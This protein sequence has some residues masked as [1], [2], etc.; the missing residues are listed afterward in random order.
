MQNYELLLSP[1]VNQ[2][3]W[4]L[5][6]VFSSSL[7]SQITKHLSTGIERKSCASFRYQTDS[8]D[9]KDDVYADIRESYFTNTQRGTYKYIDPEFKGRNTYRELKLKS[10]RRERNKD[11]RNRNGR[12]RD[13]LQALNSFCARNLQD[14]DK[15]K[16]EEILTEWFI[17]AARNLTVYTLMQAWTA[18]PQTFLKIL[19]WTHKIEKI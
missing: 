9:E 17:F 19:L 1:E 15:S 3:A 12:D 5:V 10:T 2:L 18:H 11:G 7:Y 8:Q 16:S 14:V 13:K 6:N 4:R